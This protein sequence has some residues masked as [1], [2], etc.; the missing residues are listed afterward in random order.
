MGI[1]VTVGGVLVSGTLID[2][3]TYFKEAAKGFASATGNVPSV[4]EFLSQFAE[5]HSAMY[6]ESEEEKLDLF[7]AKPA[8]YI[9]LKDA[10][11]FTP[12]GFM[13]NNQGL[14]WRGRL[15]AVEGFAFGNLT[16][17]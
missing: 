1:T 10:R 17:N 13:P 11:F 16:P 4:N 7:A 2:G 3:A 12:G 5:A 15:A 9:H 8:S 6:E 14:L